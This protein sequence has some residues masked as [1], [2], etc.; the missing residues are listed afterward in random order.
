ML[1]SDFLNRV[2]AICRVSGTPYISLTQDPG[3]WRQEVQTGL[4]DYTSKT[5]C[6]QGL[7]IAFTPVIGQQAFDTFTVPNTQGATTIP[8]YLTAAFCDVRQVVLNGQSIAVLDDSDAGTVT[9]ALTQPTVA[10]FGESSE[11]VV[12]RNFPSYLTAANGLPIAWWQE[13]PNKLWFNCPF[14]QA[15]ASCF[16]S[17]RLYH[18]PL[19]GGDGQVLQLAPEDEMLAAD[20]CAAR[21][22]IVNDRANG[23]ALLQSTLSKMEKRKGETNR[24]SGGLPKRGT[25]NA[26]RS[27]D[28]SR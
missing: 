23:D 21:I 1:A 16:L 19:T 8:T 22:I 27:I 13:S 2:W 18:D 25:G 11:L 28:L 14:D 9:D 6:L 10:L 17:G 3:A 5:Q 12:R 15:Y 26:R 24:K 7:N 4:Q 20:Y